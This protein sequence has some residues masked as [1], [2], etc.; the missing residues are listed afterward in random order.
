MNHTQRANWNI[1]RLKIAF[2]GVF[3]VACAGIWA[4]HLYYA[5]PRDKCA[6]QHGLWE[7]KSRKCTFPPWIQCENGGGWWEPR[8][9]TCAKVVN[10]P[11][12][13]GRP[14]KVIQ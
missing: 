12:M 1:T 9:R 5:W 2:V 4:Y 13:T 8:T 7:G 11:T 14:A 6:E 3:A 10:V